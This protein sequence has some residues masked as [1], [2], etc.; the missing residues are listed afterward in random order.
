MF[1]VECYPVRPGRDVFVGNVSGVASDT[2]GVAGNL[3]DGPAVETCRLKSCIRARSTKNDAI[4]PDPQRMREAISPL[5][6]QDSPAKPSVIDGTLGKTVNRRLN[7]VRRITLNG[8]DEN[9]GPDIGNRFI[10][11]R[12]PRK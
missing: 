12:K 6:E 1:R 2:V 4:G 10:S 8:S 5:T 3:Y 7:P 9:L 11:A